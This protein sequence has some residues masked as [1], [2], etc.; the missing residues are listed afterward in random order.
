M[1]EQTTKTD[2]I[3]RCVDC[4]AE[5]VTRRGARCSSCGYRHQQE[6][7]RQAYLEKHPKKEKPTSVKKPSHRCEVC[8]CVV[9]NSARWCVT[10]RIMRDL[11]RA[12]AMRHG[13][14]WPGRVNGPG[15]RTDRTCRDCGKL[16][17]EAYVRRCPDCRTAHGVA[18]YKAFL[19]QRQKATVEKHS[20]EVCTGQCETSTNKEN[21]VNNH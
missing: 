20:R 10:H 15:S 5:M 7:N 1:E 6:R 9:F 14:S 16:L 17:T 12:R 3:R 19:V 4:G 2:D 11:E 21:N 8:G 18:R 13:L